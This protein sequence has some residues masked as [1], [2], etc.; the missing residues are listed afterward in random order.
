[1]QNRKT[2]RTCVINRF[3]STRGYLTDFKKE[4]KTYSELIDF[5]PRVDESSK[6]SGFVEFKEKQEVKENQKMKKR[7]GKKSYLIDTNKDSIC[8]WS[9]L[10]S[11]HSN[12][13]EEMNSVIP[14]T[15]IKELADDCFL[16]SLENGLRH[17]GIWKYELPSAS[18]IKFAS[19]ET[20]FSQLSIKYEGAQ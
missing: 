11:E 7:Q 19:F 20:K 16:R 3:E 9:D 2:Y 12:D 8:D 18:T 15:Q 5:E 17:M 13:L 4:E 10:T 1:M 14:R 6:S